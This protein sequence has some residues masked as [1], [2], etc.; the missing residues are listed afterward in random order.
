M[1]DMKNF[2]N[3]CKHPQ[4]AIFF[5]K[6][7]LKQCWLGGYVRDILSNREFPDIDIATDA[8]PEQVIK[9]L[10]IFETKLVGGAFGVVLVRAGGYEY[11]YEIV[12]FCKDLGFS[13]GEHPGRELIDKNVYKNCPLKDNVENLKYVKLIHDEEELKWFFDNILPELKPTET[14]FLS[15]SARSKYL[16]EEEKVS[17]ELGY[18]EM[19]AKT[20]VRKRNWERFLRTVRKLE[21]DERGIHNQK[22]FTYSNKSNCMLYQYQS[23]RYT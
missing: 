1:V 21:C 20:I 13:D 11:E 7:D 9:S 4:F 15:L 6:M 2:T 18:T 19:F 12:T 17:L 14:Y 8:T 16:T 3:I 23:F 10:S 5:N 22:Q